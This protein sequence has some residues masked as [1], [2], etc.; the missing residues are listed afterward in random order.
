MELAA[1][2]PQITSLLS[3]ETLSRVERMRIQPNRRLTTHMRG[4]HLTGKG[5]QS[6]E[7][8]DYRD[9]V[10]GD[11]IRYVDWNIF[12]RLRRPYVKLFHHEEEMHVV[13]A[14][15]GSNSM[16]FENKLERAKQ[17]AAAF[18]VMGLFSTERVS[19]VAMI[20]AEG[21]RLPKLRPCTG[22]ASMPKVLAFLEGIEGGGS[23]QF[24]D[25]VEAMLRD[26][27]GR[28]VVVLLSDFLSFR[29]L[30]PPLTRLASAGLEIMGVQILAPTEIDPELD[31][32]LRFVDSEGAGTLDVSAAG[33]V[34][35][36][37][38]EYRLRYERR[39]DELCRQRGGRFVSVSSGDGIES[40]LFDVLMRAGWVR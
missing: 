3:N 35:S 12:S 10:E 25:G 23:V 16:Q 19:A 24:E 22:R 33:D 37:Y 34:V 39:L 7:F 40:I 1:A 27:R 2:K 14:I 36:L 31:G 15:D 13:L 29:D 17:L 32:D 6:T 5:G 21:P 11:D 28:G 38:Q 9:Y 26:H 18:G 30:G 4:E 20:D 8:S